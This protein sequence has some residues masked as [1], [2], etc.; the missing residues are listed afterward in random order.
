[1]TEKWKLARDETALGSSCLAEVG[2]DAEV[3]TEYAHTILRVKYGECCDNNA[4]RAPE[5]LEPQH[6]TTSPLD[7]LTN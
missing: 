7:P 4:A 3:S 5:L 6:S 2:C 1:M